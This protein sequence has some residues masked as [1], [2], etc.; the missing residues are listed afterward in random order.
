MRRI[1]DSLVRSG[2]EPESADFSEF[3]VGRHPA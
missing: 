1:R 3:F 2:L